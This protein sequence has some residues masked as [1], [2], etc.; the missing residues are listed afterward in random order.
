[1]IHRDVNRV[2]H[3]LWISDIAGES[4]GLLSKC[5]DF[6]PQSFSS[7]KLYIGQRNYSTLLSETAG[8]ACSN[9]TYAPV[10]TNGASLPTNSTR[11]S[12]H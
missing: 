2:L 5:A 1:V 12:A 8:C 9:A 4:D 3:R 7:L 6:I 11:D 10:I